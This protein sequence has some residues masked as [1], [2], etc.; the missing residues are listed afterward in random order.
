M[1][2]LDAPSPLPNPPPLFLPQFIRVLLLLYPFLF[3]VF[4]GRSVNDGTYELYHE[5]GLTGKGGSGDGM[6][7]GERLGGRKKHS[8]FETVLLFPFFL[9]PT[10]IFLHFLRERCDT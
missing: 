7:V 1:D 4:W 8:A 2:Q 3:F 5:N 10:C 6:V 9:T